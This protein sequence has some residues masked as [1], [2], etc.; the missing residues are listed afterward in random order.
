M[1]QGTQKKR[2]RQEPHSHQIGITDR[3]KRVSHPVVCTRSMSPASRTCI[4]ASATCV[5]LTVLPGMIVSGSTTPANFS[6]STP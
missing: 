6:V 1:Y 4:R 2:P 3:K 5:E